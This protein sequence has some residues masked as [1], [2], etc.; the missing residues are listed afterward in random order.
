MYSE[1]D[2]TTAVFSVETGTIVSAQRVASDLE[3]V[4]YI[5]GDMRLV[6]GREVR[7]EIYSARGKWACASVG[8]H[9]VI[10]SEAMGDIFL[11]MGGVDIWKNERPLA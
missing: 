10:P 3:G 2:S 8:G 6:G 9:L 4:F 1:I 7:I 5:E 11:A